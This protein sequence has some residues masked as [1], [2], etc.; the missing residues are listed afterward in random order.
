ML[1]AIPTGVKIFNWLGTVWGGAVR[2]AT[3]MLF[4]LGFIAMFTLGG[5][6]GVMHSIV[7][8]DSQQT[9]TY[10]VV[11]HFHYVLFGG[12][13]FAIFGGFYY[14]WPKAFGKMLD[15]RLGKLN[16][17]LMLI[18]FNL[19]FF[20]MHIVGLEGMPRRTYTYGK[21]LG[22]DTLNKME[23]VGGFIIALSVLVFIV[24]VVRTQVRGEQAPE[25]PW[26]ARTLEWTTSVAAARVQLRGRADRHASR[27]VLAPQV[28]RRRRGP[29][30]EAAA[31]RGRYGRSRIARSHPHAVAVV[32]AVRVRARPAGPRL[33]LR[34]QELV[35][36]GRRRGLA[37]VRHDRVGNR[38]VDGARD[39]DATTTIATTDHGE[40]PAHAGEHA[41][42]TGV[43]N[44]KLAIW[45]FLGSECLFFGA[46]ISTYLLYRGRDTAGPKPK[47][48]FEV[49]FTSATSF[50]LLMSSLTM[51][52]AL[53]AIQRGDH[54]RFRIW[55]ASTALFGLTFVGGQVYEF[56]QLLP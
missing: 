17:W 7:P 5:L 1:I 16:F 19:T 8:A 23:T 15:E 4:S 39:H 13:V 12:L 24:N 18:G 28:H 20:P 50:I 53:A 30:G 27:R 54:R 46:F 2:L 36:P 34:V 32:L 49:P 11:A 56:T 48:L 33:R 26:D 45:A 52:L 44:I 21:G 25:D 14:W 3:P 40:P 9:D 55:I 29:A 42:S 38:A 31:G 51:V 43:S 6:S 10:F 35:D 47:E 22:W 41:T 37:D